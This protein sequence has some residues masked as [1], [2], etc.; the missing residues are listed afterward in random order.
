MEGKYKKDDGLGPVEVFRR[1]GDLIFLFAGQEQVAQ[2]V[3]EKGFSITWPEWGPARFELQGTV[4]LE[5]GEHAWRP[6]NNIIPSKKSKLKPLPHPIDA[7][8]G[9]NSV[10]NLR[11]FRDYGF[12][13]VAGAIPRRYAEEAIQTSATAEPAI[14][15]LLYKTK[16]W[17]LVRELLGDDA[18]PPKFAQ[19]AVKLPEGNSSAP[20]A[21]DAFPPDYHIDGMHTADNNVASGAVENFSILVGVALTS[22]PLPC[23]GNLGVF[24]GS[25][26]ALAEAFRRHPRGV[27]AMADDV[28]TSNEWNNTWTWLGCQTLRQ[29]FVQK[30]GMGFCST[31]KPFTLYN[32][33]ILPALALM[34]TLESGVER[35]FI[36]R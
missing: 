18:V 29:R 15:D 6:T 4:L 21:P 7:Y 9:P 25:H 5:K 20:G 22:T 32:Q 2:D 35:A 26:T 8:V 24:P 34:F 12:N 28:G 27:A 19:V 1:N 36:I 33:T 11:F 30:Q 17:D 31:I 13:I 10:S 23:T 16:L 14:V 3:N